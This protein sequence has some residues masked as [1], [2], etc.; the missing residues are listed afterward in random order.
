MLL[1]TLIAAVVLGILGMVPGGYSALS[2]GFGLVFGC[3]V[4]GILRPRAAIG[5][6]ARWAV[7]GWMTAVLMIP[8]CFAAARLFWSFLMLFI[9]IRFLRGQE[10]S[11]VERYRS[12][13]PAL[14]ILFAWAIVFPGSANW[15]PVPEWL[16]MA[17]Y[18]LAT[19]V[20]AWRLWGPQGE[21]PPPRSP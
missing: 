16:P 7:L 5:R 19:V 13:V 14:V 17:L 11:I 21:R 6:L 8:R 9:L 4:L 20:G 12:F 1:V 2:A 15:V 18:L 10:D 3:L